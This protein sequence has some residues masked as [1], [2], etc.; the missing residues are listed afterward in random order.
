MGWWKES[1][2]IVKKND[3]AARTSLEVL[4]TYPGLKALAAHRI[5]HFL[6]RHHCRLLA[7]MHSQFWRFWTQI[8][9]HPGAQIAEGVFIDHGSGLVIGETAV[10]EKG[11][12]LYHGVTFLVFYMVGSFVSVVSLLAQGKLV[13]ALLIIVLVVVLCLYLNHIRDKK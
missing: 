5:S 12:M 9:I 7:R 4:L 2:D 6:W 13:S 10:V 3:P 1:I 8:E 11:A